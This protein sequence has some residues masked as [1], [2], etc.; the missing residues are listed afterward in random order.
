MPNSTPMKDNTTSSANGRRSGRH[1]EQQDLNHLLGFTL[2]PRAP[3][4]PTHLPRRSNRRNPNH[5]VFDRARFVHQFRFVVKPDKDYTVQFA[6]PDIHLDW[7]DVL[8][9]ILPTSASALSSV[10]TTKLDQVVDGDSG[11]KSAMPACP[12]CLSEP[13]APRMTKCGHV[14][15]YPCILHYLALAE[16]GHKTRQCPI[17]HDSVHSKD[18]KSVKWFQPDL[19]GATSTAGVTPVEAIDSDLA[20]A[21]EISKLDAQGGGNLASSQPTSAKK[22]KL[23]MRLIRRPQ[24][25]TL[26]LPR[27]TTWPSNAVPPL[28]APW[29]FTPDAFTYAKFVLGAPDY[30]RDELLSQKAQ[31]EAEIQTLR[32]FGFRGGTDEQ[33]G[34]VFIDAALR[35]VDEQLQKVELLKTTAVM[36]ARKRSLRELHEIQELRNVA[37]TGGR[38][39]PVTDT[40]ASELETPS[41]VDSSAAVKT[42][43]ASSRSPLPANPVYD[44][45]PLDFLHTR[46]T[47]LTAGAPP[48][49]PPST[50]A[51]PVVSA[52]LS[53]ARARTAQKRTGAAAEQGGDDVAYYFYQAASGQPI[54]L[55]PLDIKVLKSHFGTY[56]AMPDDIEVVVEGADEGSMNDELRRRCKWL[57]HLPVASDVV[58]IEADLTAVVPKKAMEPYA[59]ALRQRRTK[60]RDK[61]RKEDRA[62]QRS[63]EKAA[64]ALP[65]HESTY[66]FG[67]TGGLPFGLAAASSWGDDHVFPATSTSPGLARGGSPPSTNLS[68]A[69]SAPARPSLSSGPRPSFASA[70]HASSPTADRPGSASQNAWDDALED[71]WDALEEELGRRRAASP[72]TATSTGANTPNVTDSGGQGKKSKKAKKLTLHLSGSALR[73]AG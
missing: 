52:T 17:C 24:I 53:P 47:P 25:T 10:S 43:P 14:F 60:R 66:A 21:L 9:V 38:L 37:G 26:A 55:S 48:F 22:E 50:A 72:R 56:Q 68:I 71:R 2:P 5:A 45:V 62:K 6:D 44:P 16:T 20:R 59:A 58:F 46:T 8:Q 57:S 51:P 49:I 13:V 42:L 27:S 36:T 67:A 32:R 28:R 15:C 69:D 23:K 1:R 31:L 12:I 29:N 70:V 65:L 7:P 30:L 3:Q 63:E 19:A 41:D 11:A 4:P 73:G 34:I 61:A 35:K 54:F 64:E 39:P 18:L 33:L 40:S